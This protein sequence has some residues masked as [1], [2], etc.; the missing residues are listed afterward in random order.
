[1]STAARAGE[2]LEHYGLGD[3]D[4]F[5]DPTC[6]LF[7]A[8][9]LA[10]GRWWQLMGPAVWRRGLV[11]I[12][13]HGLGPIDGDGFQMPGTFLLKDGKIAAAYRHRT[14]ADRPDYRHLALSSGGT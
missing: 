9:E 3:I 12:F 6:R 2:L 10:R 8:F 4:Q 7:R 11:T 5:S 1:M 14:A 13:R